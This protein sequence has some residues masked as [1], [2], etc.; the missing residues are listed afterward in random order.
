MIRLIS[1]GYLNSYI[2][3]LGVSE[4]YRN[5]GIGKK[6]MEMMT[7]FC[8]NENLNP[9]FFCEEHLISFYEKIGYKVFASGMR[10]KQSEQNKVSIR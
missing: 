9:Q 6:L 8:R 7:D 5:Q 4:G 2:C 10:I 3:G 1:D